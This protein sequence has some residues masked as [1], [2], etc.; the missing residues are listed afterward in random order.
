MSRIVVNAFPFIRSF[1]ITTIFCAV[2]A[3]ITM[4]IWSGSYYEHLSISFGYGYS[5][6]FC[7]KLLE[8]FYPN[9]STRTTNVISLTGAM[10]FGSL[11]AHLWL[12]Y[13][14][15]FSSL[16]GLLPVMALGLVFSSFCFFYFYSYEKRLIAERELEVARRKQSEDEKALILSQLKQLQSQ[17]EPHFLFNTLA[18]V[19]VL[20]DQDSAKAREMLNRLTELLRATLRSSRRQYTSLDQETEMLSAYLEIQKIRLGSRLDYK[21]ECEPHLKK[22]AIPPLLIQPMVENAIT[23]GIEPKGEG[24]RVLLK[25]NMDEEAL[26]IQVTD[27]GKGLNTNNSG[28]SGNGMALNNIRG[29]LKALFEGQASLTIQ[30]NRGGGVTALIRISRQKLGELK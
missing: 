1:I 10:V 30:E 8:R 23:H 9:L 25:I 26:L 20:I 18:N 28:I 17:I 24:G 15:G 16:E 21:I 3:I 5:A 22:L 11:N 13:Y 12:K 4:S 27:N 19:S 6:L 7:E 2:I 14:E 29:R